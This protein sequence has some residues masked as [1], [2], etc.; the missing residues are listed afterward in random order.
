MKVDD[1]LVQKPLKSEIYLTLKSSNM[2][3]T[4]CTTIR[5]SQSNNRV[6]LCTSLMS[7]V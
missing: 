5:K 7:R 6:I 3:S 2:H 1:A 4:G